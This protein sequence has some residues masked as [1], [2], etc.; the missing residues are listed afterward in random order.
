MLKRSTLITA[1]LPVTALLSQASLAAPTADQWQAINVQLSQHYVQ[2]RYQELANASQQLANATSTLCSKNNKRS[3][4][5]SRDAFH[6]TMDAW[7]GIQHVQFGPVEFLMRNF[8]LQFWPDKK[9]LTS[10]QL[11]TL[12]SEENPDN[13]T[14]DYFRGASIA[15]KG[16]PALE[17]LLFGNAP[18]SPYG[19]Q[20]THAIANNVA[21]VID[22]RC[23]A[24]SWASAGDCAHRRRP[25]NHDARLVHMGARCPTALAPARSTQSRRPCAVWARSTCGLCAA[26]TAPPSGVGEEHAR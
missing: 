13:L 2:P 4:Q 17:R 18:L 1:L 26:W 9:N 16:L 20:L 21:A 8:S 22:T 23:S 6:Q 15:V 5:E 24:H 12:L 14:P 11:N 3:L 7:Q 10:K 25:S 19:C